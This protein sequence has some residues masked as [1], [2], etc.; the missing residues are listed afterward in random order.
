MVR[1]GDLEM[2]RQVPP[3]QEAP[4][5][6]DHDAARVY[7]YHLADRRH[8]AGYRAGHRSVAAADLQDALTQLGIDPGERRGEMGRV[9]VRPRAVEQGY[10][11]IPMLTLIDVGPSPLVVVACHRH[12]IPTTYPPIPPAATLC[13]HLVPAATLCFQVYPPPAYFRPYKAA[14][15]CVQ[16]G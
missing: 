2:H 6:G 13:V 3:G 10:V 4:R 7:R 15:L 5:L 9:V 14:N 8:R 16:R 12:R 1:V 11:T